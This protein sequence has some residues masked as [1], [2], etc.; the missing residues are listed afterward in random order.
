[1][2]IPILLDCDPGHDDMMAIMLAVAHESID[3]LGVTTVAGNQTGENTWRNAAATLTLIEALHVPLARGSDQPLCRPLVTAPNIH[4]S[5]GLDG[6]ELPDPAPV[7]LAEV[8][9][10]HPVPGPVRM[11]E[12]IMNNPKPVTLV[13]TGPL[14]NV[15][16]ALRTFPGLHRKIRRIV[17]MGG[18][19]QDSNITPAAEFNIFVDPEAAAAIFSC[20]VP[21]TM[22]SVD[23][24]NQAVMNFEEIAAL[25]RENGPVSGV[26]G[27]LMRF[28]AERNR[29]AFGIQGAPIHDALTVASVIEPSLVTTRKC[30]VVVETSGE[31]TRGRT[32]VDLYGVTGRH[33]NAEV[34]FSVDRE[35]FIAMMLEALRTLDQRKG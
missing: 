26:V 7:F 3:L 14:T 9:Q 11:A 23:V 27:R 5:S 4:G 29:A 22:V 16:L 18:G 35:R 20:G 28:F 24:T 21:I 1:M 6:A 19:L 10:P 12:L 32:V 17:I 15:A 31:H 13:P 2:A 34:T 30:N 8:R 25:E 33:P